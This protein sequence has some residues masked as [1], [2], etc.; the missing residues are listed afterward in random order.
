MLA[1]AWGW[2][3]LDPGNH[4]FFIF[5]RNKNACA[6][7]T[8]GIAELANMGFKLSALGL[9]RL[10]RASWRRWP[11]NLSL[12]DSLLDFG[13]AEDAGKASQVHAGKTGTRRQNLQWGPDSSGRQKGITPRVASVPDY[14][15]C[16]FTF[17]PWN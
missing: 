11:R 13:R 3:T 1:Q 5:Q 12:K 17:F 7:R 8:P 16:I 9:D 10:G 6:T 14:R 15:L 2:E 4:F